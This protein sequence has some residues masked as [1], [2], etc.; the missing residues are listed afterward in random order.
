MGKDVDPAEI[1]KKT[2]EEAREKGYGAVVVDTAGRQ[3]VNTPNRNSR[4]AAKKK[5]RYND[6]M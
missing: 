3:V 5:G 2:V 1:A 4:R 6:A